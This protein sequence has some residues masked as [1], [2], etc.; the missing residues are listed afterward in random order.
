[1]YEHDTDTCRLFSDLQQ[2]SDSIERDELYDVMLRMGIPIKM[3]QLTWMTTD[4]IS[5]KV[6]VENKFREP[7]EFSAGVKQGDRLSTALSNITW[8]LTVADQNAF[9]SFERRI[10]RK[11]FGSV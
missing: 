11:V 7:T 5:A 10:L 9:T 2:A 6:K 3:I 1:M 4:N 8:S